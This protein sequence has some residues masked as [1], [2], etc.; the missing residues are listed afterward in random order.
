[1]ANTIYDVVTAPE[2]AAYWE[3]NQKYEEPYFGESKFPNA[4]K[5]G[6]DLSWI[7]GARRAPVSLSLSAFDVDVLP[8]KRGEFE[9]LS[10]EMPFF[11]NEYRI[12]ERTRQDLN[13]LMQAGNAGVN[14]LIGR[15]FDDEANLLRNAAL[16][17]EM[18]RMQLLTTGMISLKDNGQ[19]FSYD[20]GVPADHKTKPTKKWSN[21]T[22]ADP[23]A[24]I[25]AWRLMIEE[26]KG[27]SPTEI[28]LNSTTL[29]L[30]AK[31][32]AIK[33]GVFANSNITTLPTR[34]Q[35]SAFLSSQLGMTVYVYDKGYNNDG[36]FVK[37]VPDKTVVLMPAT[38]LGNTWF[39]TTPE[40]SDLQSGGTAAQVSVVDTGVAI[41]TWKLEDPVNV[42]TKASQIVLPS[43][44]LADEVI[45]ADISQDAE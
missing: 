25:D 28:L 10:T 14:T 15:I 36:K 30:L 26:E 33:N 20:F 31:T 32:D 38:T 43:F 4:K 44:E 45:I 29:A 41:T 13:V 16:T 3:E 7:K 1:M 37:F 35:V 18:L 23:I 2:I 6:L 40:E 12:D 34:A 39:G 5:L 11:K 21:T 22:E 17:R 9:K 24:D 42:R 8:L 27:V 19:A